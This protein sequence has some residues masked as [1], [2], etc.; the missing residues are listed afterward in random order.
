[1]Y[2]QI[3]DDWA[4]KRSIAKDKERGS[5]TGEWHPSGMVECLRAAVYSF[6]GTPK[7]D[8]KAARN[9]RIM[10]RGTEVHETVQGIMHAKYPDFIAEVPV[11]WQGF[12]GSADGLLPIADGVLNDE[13][14]PTYELQEYKS[15]SPNAKR[16]MKAPKEGHVKQARLYYMCLEEQGYL[17]EGIRIVYFDRDDWN[18]IEFEVE[19]WTP[20]EVEAFLTEVDVLETHA[21]EGTLPDRMPDDFWLCR[22]CDWRT[23]CKG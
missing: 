6:T 17:L 18:V 21:E 8:E 23:T 22:F 20:E 12:H 7:S 14:V 9:I 4:L 15:M 2:Q 11:R 10:D 19:P 13:V 3:I 1:M 16:W 5:D